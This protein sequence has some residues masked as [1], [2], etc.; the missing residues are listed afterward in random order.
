MKLGGRLACLAF[1]L[2]TLHAWAAPFDDLG[3]ELVY[4]DNLT[5]AQLG[6]D[7]KGDLALAVSTSGGP[8]FQLGDHD[9]L[10]LKGTLVATKYRH[11]DGLDNINAG[12]AL[13]YRRKF[14]LGPYVPQLALTGSAARLEYDSRLRDGWLYAA[15]A[16][17]SKRVSDRLALRA[18]VRSERREADDVPERVVPF[19]RANVFD[20]GS[21]SAGI[22][23]DFAYDPRHLVSIG[24]TWHRGDIVSTTQRNLPVF[25][26]SSAIAPDPVFGDDTY[27]YTMHARTRV[28]SIGLSR[29][30]SRQA[31]FSL[32]YEY[33]DSRADGGIDYSGNLFRATYLYGF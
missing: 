6:R 27:A 13:G 2:S 7:I 32:G 24:Y 19:I 8:R 18:F 21:R 4:D 33:R 9:S 17:A 16:E 14:G 11:Y 15:E 22:G 28:F 20:L 5:R 3:V 23:A 10:S 1:A 31:S 30:L 26:A 29:E 25:L 12:L